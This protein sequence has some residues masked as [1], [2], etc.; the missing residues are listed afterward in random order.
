MKK[1]F[2][3]LMISLFMYANATADAGIGFAY[4]KTAMIYDSKLIYA[5]FLSINFYADDLH[6]YIVGM[7]ISYSPKKNSFEMF[8]ADMYIGKRLFV[9][10]KL[11]HWYFKVG[12]S[13]ATIFFDP[14]Y[15]ADNYSVK[16]GVIAASGFHVQVLKGVKLFGEYE[17][18]KYSEV[19]TYQMGS[20]PDL[21]FINVLPKKDDLKDYNSR[22]SFIKRLKFG[23][24]FSM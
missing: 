16:L 11:I 13:V 15:K 19:S 17:F 10:P 14:D 20:N 21:E 18:R 9:F 6:K 4:K 2:L 3:T 22:K 8:T 12:P 5:D 7:N 24:K 23:M 1:V